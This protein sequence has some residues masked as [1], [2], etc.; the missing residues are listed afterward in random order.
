[1][2]GY[3]NEI[4]VQINIKNFKSSFIILGLEK[5][6]EEDIE[7]KEQNEEEKEEE[8]KYK[9]NIMILISTLNNFRMAQRIAYK[10][11]PLTRFF[12]GRQFRL[13]Y[14]I[15]KE[16]KIDKDKLF[17]FLMLLS[18]N[19]SYK[20]FENMYYDYHDDYNMFKNI[21]RFLEKILKKFLYSE[22]IY[23]ETLIKKKDKEYEE[24]KGVYLY[25]SYKL[26]NDLTLI[27]KYLTGNNPVAKAVL[28]CNKETT[29]EELTSFLYRSILCEYNSC[30]IIGGIEF[31]EYNK[32]SKLLELLYS[33]Y[34]KDYEYMS[35]C[36]I[37]LYTSRK[38]DIFKSLDSLK[39]RNILDIKK[40]NFE[41]L[42][43]IT[44]VEIFSSDFSGVGKSTEIKR[45]VEKEHKKYIYFPLGGV[46]KRQDIIKRL[47]KLKFSK[48]SV[49]HLDLY[50]TEQTDVMMEFLFSILITKL[51]GRNENI[52]YLYNEVDIK[53]EIQ[54]GFIDFLHKYPILTFFHLKKLSINKLAP[55][56]VEND[57]NSNAQIVANYLK[58][59]KNNIID[60]NDL[61]FEK[62]SPEVFS[63]YKTKSDATILSQEECQKL[64]FDE[65]K[66]T[67]KVPNYYQITN[68]INIL[69]EEFSKFSKNFY[70]EMNTLVYIKKKIPFRKIIIESLIKATNHFCEGAFRNIIN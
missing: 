54:N 65:I 22:N 12:Y 53:I 5:D 32:K 10:D 52:F 48:D 55:L 24:C 9:K 11:F 25:L 1:M 2:A 14:N 61:Y 4:E 29:N 68:F 30:F 41:K 3:P 56:I 34:V 51:Y 69:A 37:I 33:L 16:K 70:F 26:E 45:L 50:D 58:A 13:I 35:S 40:E 21:Q 60:K 18:N 19:F 27:Y 46:L 38:T 28:L 62:I 39:Y 20:L 15:L 43:I 7:E 57:L 59:L 17:P 47:K 23:E 64:I 6:I 44:N 49:L 8:K 31:L 36:L 42:Q 66:N 67:I 63:N